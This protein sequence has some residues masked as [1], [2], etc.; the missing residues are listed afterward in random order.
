MCA[1]NRLYFVLD[2]NLPFSTV[3]QLSCQFPDPSEQ[4]VQIIST[5]LPTRTTLDAMITEPM[6]P[7]TILATQLLQE[8]PSVI[9][10]QQNNHN[11]LNVQQTN[12]LGQLLPRLRK[13]AVLTG[14]SELIKLTQQAQNAA[15]KILHY[16][17]SFLDR[18]PPPVNEYPFV[19]NPCGD[20]TE[21]RMCQS[22]VD[23]QKRNSM[24]RGTQ[25][26][27]DVFSR[28]IEKVDASTTT[29]DAPSFTL[30]ESR[31]SNGMSKNNA[32]S[33]QSK[34]VCDAQT[35]AVVDAA[36]RPHS[37]DEDVSDHRHRCDKNHQICLAQ[38]RKQLASEQAQ[39][40]N[41]SSQLLYCQRGVEKM[42]LDY[43]QHE[44]E[45]QADLR[46][47]QDRE[48]QLI[49]SNTELRNELRLADYQISQ[50]K[51]RLTLVG[52]L[53]PPNNSNK[54]PVDAATSDRTLLSD[55]SYTASRSQSSGPRN[56]PLCCDLQPETAHCVE[57]KSKGSYVDPDTA[58]LLTES[59]SIGSPL[60]FV[61]QYDFIVQHHI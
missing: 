59:K 34:H 43:V 13:L 23:C 22:A 16:Y 31:M 44:A 12:S 20:P 27:A 35:S 39:T 25:A 56:S 40:R 36:V 24:S 46:A 21:D 19:D 50:L 29:R 41:L 61:H 51:F 5:C 6:D 11:V 60:R 10:L 45:L 42:R 57:N 55:F 15:R 17:G 53:P 49:K 58:P 9:P 32:Q 2:R 54:C 52:R 47:C 30:E 1:S 28:N 48:S 4:D 7:V 37:E 26:T 3:P 8:D 33:T 38:L 14:S 18:A